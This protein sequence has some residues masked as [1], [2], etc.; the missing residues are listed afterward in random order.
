LVGGGDD[1]NR[2]GAVFEC[3]QGGQ[4][5]RGGGVSA[6]GLEQA[7]TE[8][9]AGFAQLFEGEKAVFFATDDVGVGDADVRGAHCG[10]TQGGLLKQ[11]FIAG[12]AKELLGEPGPG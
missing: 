10:Q 12:K 9:D 11:A 1:E 6:D 8:R 2:V 4:G 3:G 5:Q 7:C